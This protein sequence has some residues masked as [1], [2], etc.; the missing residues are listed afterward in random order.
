MI[1]A[2]HLRMTVQTA[3]SKQVLRRGGICEP[4]RSIRDARVSGLRVAAL[5]KQWC[6]LRQ[7]AGVVRAV[8]RVTD[9]AVFTDRR[10]LP[11]VWATLFGVTLLAGVV[12]GLPHEPGSDLV[13]MRAV[14][15]AA[16]HL[17]LEE[18]M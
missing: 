11:E 13:A 9:S 12:H 4:L 8:R 10:V 6:A 2:V 5:A 17:P 7:H 14:T 18:W 3:L 16:V 15:A 1:R